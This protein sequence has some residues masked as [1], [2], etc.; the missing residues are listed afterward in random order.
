[1]KKSQGIIRVFYAN[2]HKLMRSGIVKAIQNAQHIQVVDEA[3][4]FTELLEKLD[5]IDADILMTDDVMPGGDIATALEQIITKR[6]NLKIIINSMHSA[7]AQHF[8]LVK[9]KAHGL[10]SFASEAEDFIRA[11][12]TVYAGGMFYYVPGFD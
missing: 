7:D 6:P 8:D 4:N 9:T 5:K 3:E 10:V 11:I 1:M 12:E 2:D